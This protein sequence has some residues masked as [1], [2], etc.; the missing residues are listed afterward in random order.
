MA[1]K[2]NIGVNGLKQLFE[3]LTQMGMCC[4]CGIPFINT[5]TCIGKREVWMISNTSPNFRKLPKA[6]INIFIQLQVMP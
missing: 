1:Q 2:C 5:K 6:Q 4:F 3:K